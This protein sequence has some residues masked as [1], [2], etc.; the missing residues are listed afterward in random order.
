MLAHARDPRSLTRRHERSPMRT[1]EMVEHLFSPLGT[2]CIRC[3]PRV[4]PSCGPS[5]RIPV[6]VQSGRVPRQNYDP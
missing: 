4:R 2:L 1:F 5:L 3:H 6:S